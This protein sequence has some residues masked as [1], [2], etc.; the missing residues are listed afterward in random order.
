MAGVPRAEA[1]L[2]SSLRIA[3]ARL[4]RRLRTQTT[5]DGLTVTQL[6]ALATLERHGPLAPSELAEHE[7]VQPPSITRV[8]NALESRGLAGRTA[9]PHDRRQ[10]V[11]TITPDGAARLAADRARR[12]AWLSRRLAD[13]GPDDLEALRAAARLLDRLGQG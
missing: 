12:D 4:A 10:V 13:L 8:I 7:K 6:A 1:A 5:D 2:A 9:H 3:V 11:V